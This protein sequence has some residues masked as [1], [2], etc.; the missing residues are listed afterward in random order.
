MDNDPRVPVQTEI[1]RAI[2][3]LT[4]FDQ[5]TEESFDSLL[6]KLQ[7]LEDDIQKSELN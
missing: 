7:Q 5:S 3:R 6:E 1:D 4:S 2:E